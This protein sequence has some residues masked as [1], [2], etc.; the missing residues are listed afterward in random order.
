M[1]PA[2]IGALILLGGTIGLSFIGLAVM[3]GR[4][5]GRLDAQDKFDKIEREQST[6]WRREHLD[7]H[8]TESNRWD[9][10]QAH[11]DSHAHAVGG[12]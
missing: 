6:G 2:V 9:R 3:Q 8:R 10:V 5:L 12:D 4:V 1:D 11:Y 7:L